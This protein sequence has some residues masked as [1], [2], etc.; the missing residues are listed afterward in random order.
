LEAYMKDIIDMADDYRWYAQ[1]S[2][3]RG[4]PYFIKEG[5]GCQHSTS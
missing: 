4:T 3:I 2:G 5:L 1:R